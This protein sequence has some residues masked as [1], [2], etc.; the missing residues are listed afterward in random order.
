M[1]LPIIV[2]VV[3]TVLAVSIGVAFAVRR[4]DPEETAKPDESA[5]ADRS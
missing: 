2:F 4:D 3:L 1:D 5:P